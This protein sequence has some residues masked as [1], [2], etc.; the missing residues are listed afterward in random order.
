MFESLG[1]ARIEG[2]HT[3][4]A[5]YVESAVEGRTQDSDQLREISNI[6][7]AMQYI[8]RTVEPG[9]PLSERFVRELHSMAVRGLAP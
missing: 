7:E 4:L 2:N 6:E 1:S 9:G 5:D 3:T 8:V